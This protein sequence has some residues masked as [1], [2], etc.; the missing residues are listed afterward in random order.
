MH[1]KRQILRPGCFICSSLRGQ[2]REGKRGRERGREG[3]R[4]EERE[5]EGKER[6]GKRGKERGERRER[7][8]EGERGERGEEREW[9][10]L[11]HAPVY[12]CVCTYVSLCRMMT[13]SFDKRVKV[14]TGDGKLVHTIQCR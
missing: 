4:G 5:R 13:G 1:S 7:G 3:E 6:E 12:V 10:P 9:C 11:N 2:Q 8:R 14:W